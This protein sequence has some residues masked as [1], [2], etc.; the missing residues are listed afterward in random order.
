[1]GYGY[2]VLPDGREAGYSVERPCHQDGCEN[3]VFRG[4]D[5]LCGSAPDGH[6]DETEAGCGNWFCPDHHAPAE[7]ECPKPPCGVYSVDGMLHCGLAEPH[8][9]PHRDLHDDETFVETET[10]DED[11]ADVDPA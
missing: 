8:D 1:M 6:R 3:T 4:L 9:L 2:Y 5:A 11:D 10:D 7:H